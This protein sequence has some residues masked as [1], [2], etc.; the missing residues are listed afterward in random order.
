MTRNLM[1]ASKWP[2]TYAEF[3]KGG[4]VHLHYIYDGDVLN[5]SKIY[6]E[7]I[8][9]TEVATVTEEKRLVMHYRGREIVNLSRKFIDSAGFLRCL[10]F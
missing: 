4:G 2:A 3:S 6:E 9:V 10:M 5:L 7:N 1:E 8:E